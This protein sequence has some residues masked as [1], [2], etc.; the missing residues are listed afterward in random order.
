MDPD[1]NYF[2]SDLNFS[3]SSNQSNL[4]SVSEYNDLCTENPSHFNI[5]SQNIR[6]FGSNSDSLLCLFENVTSF[7]D[8]LILTETW[9]KEYNT[10]DIPNY[11]SYHTLRHSGR[12]GGVST[13]VKNSIFSQPIAE[14]SFAN[15]TIEISTVHIINSNL[16]VFILG[17]YR[18]HSDSIENFTSTLNEIFNHDI[19]RNKNFIVIGD[20]NINLL[21]N[22]LDVNNFL[23]MMQSYHLI[24]I[25]TKPTCFPANSENPSLLDHIWINKITNYSC[26]VIES[27]LTDH[28]PIF[29]RIPIRNIS[30]ENNFKKIN[31]RLVNDLNKNNFKIAISNFDWSSLRCSD[32]N[33]FT[34][35]LINKLN[36][37]YCKYFPLKFKN[38]KCRDHNNPC[39]TRSISKLILAKSSCFKLFRLGL[40]T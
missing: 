20:L 33:K 31:F 37:F 8:V 11:T 10:Q 26:G 38:V 40:V 9:F 29:I 39:F 25:I 1:N 24:P 28:C 5:F 34:E 23:T 13:F 21:L 18:P 14:L 6:S 36:F 17:I 3:Y 32:L 19:I 30:S 35:N 4:I 7:P 16:N 2:N 27:D 22:N 15:N 12:S